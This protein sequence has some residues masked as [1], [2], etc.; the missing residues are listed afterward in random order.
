MGVNL[1]QSFI[2][3]SLIKFLYKKELQRPDLV[4][5]IF[6]S[7]SVLHHQSSCV[8]A[9]DHRASSLYDIVSQFFPR[10]DQYISIPVAPVSLHNVENARG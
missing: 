7:T 4:S 6:V 8:S 3:L 9:T 10:N 2:D 5:C 1:I